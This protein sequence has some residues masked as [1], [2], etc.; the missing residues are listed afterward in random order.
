MQ[1]STIVFLCLSLVIGFLLFQVKY[2]VVEIEENLSRATAQMQKERENLHVLKAEWSLLN[3]PQRLEKLAEKFLD[4]K[5]TKVEQYA[6]LESWDGQDSLSSP[7]APTT[8]LASYTGE[9]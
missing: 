1:R 9:T 7:L 3:D 4:V 8:H 6:S 2:A 5:A